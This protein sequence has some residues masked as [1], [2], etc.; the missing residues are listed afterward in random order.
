MP[1]IDYITTLSAKLN[2]PW[3]TYLFVENH[4]F[5]WNSISKEHIQEKTIHSRIRDNRM[6]AINVLVMIK[7]E[8]QTKAEHS[9]DVGSQGKEEEEE[10]SVISPA[11]AVIDPWTVVVKVL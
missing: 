9:H 1:C 6:Q 2:E 10:V 11:N 8:E 5:I 3:Q 7:D 4:I